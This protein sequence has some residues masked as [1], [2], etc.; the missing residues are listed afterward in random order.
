MRRTIV[1]LTTM[2]ITLLVATSVA[3]AATVRCP[4]SGNCSGTDAADN[5]YAGEGGNVIF[6]KGGNDSIFG[7]LRDDFIVGMDGDDILSGSDGNDTLAGGDGNDQLTGS[8]G[9]D[10][11]DGG[12]GYD[13]YD[14]HT[15]YGSSNDTYFGLKVNSVTG[16]PLVT[17]QDH[18]EDVGGSSDSLDLSTLNRSQVSIGW[19]DSN[20]DADRNLDTMFAELKGTT[21]ND[22]M[23]FYNY[24]DNKGGTGQGYGAI[25]II[26]FKDG[27]YTFPIAKG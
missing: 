25:E 3:W 24:F 11:Y 6:G 14:D 13:F 9:N 16:A 10:T 23:I 21:T 8:Y 19:Y 20:I 27:T 12:P 5:I 2:A 7:R 26:K 17:N 15:R 18:V 1:L 22:R 4:Y